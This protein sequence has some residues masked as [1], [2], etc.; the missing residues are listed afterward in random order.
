VPDNGS[1]RDTYLDHTF[2]STVRDSVGAGRGR[3]VAVGLL[4]GLALFVLGVAGSS[5]FV[6]VTGALMVAA[7]VSWIV[8]RWRERK[9][10][11]RI[12]RRF[13]S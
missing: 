12:R 6:A 8:R 11:D 4:F 5:V 2:F 9:R 10:A 13:S 3:V 1:L 7:S